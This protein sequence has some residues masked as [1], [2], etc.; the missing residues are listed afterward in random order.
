[1]NEVEQ[2]KQKIDIVGLISEHIPLKKMGLNFKANCPFHGEKTPSFVVSSERQIWHCFGCHKGGDCFS[3]LMDFENLEFPEALRIL[4]KKAGVELK[5][6]SWQAGQT[7]QKERIYRL[8]HLAA[9]FYH[10]LLTKHNVGKNALEYLQKRGIREGTLNTFML[11][12][13][14]RTNNSLTNYLLKKKG[15][16]KEDLIEAGLV[17]QRG[18]EVVDFFAN[19]IIFPLIDHRGN[20]IGFSGR[21]LE[22]QTMASKY[23]NT[24]ETAVYH[25][26][27]GFFG[28]NIGKEEIKKE[29]F[30]IVTEGEFDVI[31]AFQEGIKN[32]VAVKGT[33]LTENQVIL[34]FRFC[35]KVSL[36]FDMDKA[37][38]EAI[39]RSLPILEKKGFTTSVIILSNGKD[40]DESI[41]NDPV[42]FKKAIKNDIGIYDFLIDQGLLKFDKNTAEGKKKIGDELLPFV[43]EIA[44]EIVKEHY[45]KKLAQS[46]ETSFESIVKQA[47]RIKKTSIIEPKKQDLKQKKIREEV[48]EEYLLALII[49]AENFPVIVKK[50]QE[51]LLD[52]LQKESSCQKIISLLLKKETL[53][54]N[55]FVKILAPELLSCFNTAFLFPIAKFEDEKEYLEEVG[56]VAGELKIAILK[57]KI[58]MINDKIKEREKETGDEDEEIENLKKEL[59]ILILSLPRN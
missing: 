42:V 52:F 29:N 35:Q 25:K 18:S 10:F 13:A 2:V 41:K 12:F 11:G 34:L 47:E 3:F 24:R 22:E 7:S 17:S 49:Q 38:Q 8:N 16:K 9:E 39:R 30:V 21:I 1:M 53:S 51:V 50:V 44:N 15:Y 36:C 32:I 56:K 46:L 28:L 4:A 54:V 19:R 45:F 43:A 26:G 20:I 37:G 40:V 58:T 59:S 48:L 57:A 27:D 55:E 33:A 23:V 5:E 31:S 14:P 6:S